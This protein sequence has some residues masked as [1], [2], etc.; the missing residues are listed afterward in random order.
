ML[1]SS[2]RYTMSLVVLRWISGCELHFWLSSQLTE[3]YS[4]SGLIPS[5]FFTSGLFKWYSTG[6]CLGGMH[7]GFSHDLL[8]FDHVSGT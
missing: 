4:S 3:L 8:T 5:S 1:L 7:R 6:Y 2:R